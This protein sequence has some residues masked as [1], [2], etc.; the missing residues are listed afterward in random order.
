MSNAEIAGQL[1]DAI[2]S[3][4]L[5]KINAILEQIISGKTISQSNIYELA[6]VVRRL[7][8]TLDNTDYKTWKKQGKLDKQLVSRKCKEALERLLEIQAITDN[9][10]SFGKK[11]LR[12]MNTGEY[13]V[14]IKK[15][16]S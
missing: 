5:S 12:R 1:K 10:N 2:A 6:V 4:E 15:R 8:G 13:L 16:R 3:R 14:Q 9:G 11:G 7:K